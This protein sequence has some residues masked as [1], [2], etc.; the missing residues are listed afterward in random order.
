METK[1]G[2]GFVKVAA[3]GY[4]LEAL[5]GWGAYRAKLTAWV[6]EAAEAGADVLV[7]PEYG[8][9]ELATLEE[10]PE[11]PDLAW[12]LS[13]VARHIPAA[14]ALHADLAAKFSVHILAGSA[15]VLS[16]EGHWVNRA[17]FFA[18]DGAMGVQD[19][20]IMTKWE[21]DPMGVQP[22]GPLT[23]FDTALGKI[24]ILICYD[25]EFPLLGRALMEADLILV[26]SCT[27]GLSGHTRV[28]VGAAARALENQCVTVVASTLGTCPW[29]E[30]VDHNTGRGAIFGP[31]DLGFPDTGI[32]A[33]GAL[34]QPGW[35]Y[36]DLD[37][38]QI[39]RVRQDGAVAG[40]ADWEQ[41][42]SRAETVTNVSLRPQNP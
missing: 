20:Q 1:D 32:L 41:Q 39:A 13:A 28:C 24:G 35:V 6:Q 9:M 29:S 2:A 15:P 36:A 38:A 22:G 42:L 19:K 18:P 16:A 14:D 4:P 11:D 17:R 27:E 30:V 25:S 37:V 23:L 12:E 10:M 3:A 21:R 31:A 33:Q 5:A 26:P 8:A 7:F 34:N 40:R